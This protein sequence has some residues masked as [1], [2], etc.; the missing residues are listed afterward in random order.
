MGDG[1]SQFL[2]FMLAVLPLL[3]KGNAGS[4][5]PLPYA[6]ALLMIP[7]LDTIAAVWRRVRDHRRI[8][9]PD[10]AHIHHKLINLGLKAGGVDAILYTL[11]IALGALVFIS[12]R[13]PGVLSLV[14]LGAAY[15]IGIGFFTTV[16]FL[17]QRTK[18]AVGSNASR[19]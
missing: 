4:N 7:I 1:G 3:D 13:T 8:D 15:V 9:S 2:G 18:T 5:L 14:L 17:N 10:R 16:H 11:Q 6:A 12:I 19:K